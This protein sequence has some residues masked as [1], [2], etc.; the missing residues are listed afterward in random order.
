MVAGGNDIGTGC[1]NLFHGMFCN[2]V[3]LGGILSVYDCHINLMFPLDRRQVIHQE[4]TASRSYHITNVQYFH[5][6]FLFPVSD[7]VCS[8]IRAD[9]AVFFKRQFPA[10]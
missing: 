10:K 5:E 1:K 3:A 2:A 4:L 8:G 9:C 7:R 6:V